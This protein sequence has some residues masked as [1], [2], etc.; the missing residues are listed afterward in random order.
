MTFAPKINRL[1]QKLTIKYLIENWEF[2]KNDDF[3]IFLE[4]SSN[5]EN[6][7]F[8]IKYLIV[9]VWDNRLIFYAKVIYFLRRIQIW[10]ISWRAHTS[11]RAARVWIWHKM[12]KNS[13]FLGK[14]S[15]SRHTQR[16]QNG[17]R[18]KIFKIWILHKK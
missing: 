17:A 1:S 14:S 8:S 5:F 11:T 6:S 9:N 15:N 12:P 10:K 4:K 18:A 2:S 3:T 13:D 7:Q 16:A